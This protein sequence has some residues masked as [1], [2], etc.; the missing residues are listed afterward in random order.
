VSLELACA[1]RGVPLGQA[2]AAIET[3]DSRFHWD[4]KVNVDSMSLSAL[5]DH[6]EATQHGYL[7]RDYAATE[8]AVANITVQQLLES[9]DPII[10]NPE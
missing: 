5:C 9:A 3:D 2:V 1:K 4:S 8:A 7:D 10:P 6:I